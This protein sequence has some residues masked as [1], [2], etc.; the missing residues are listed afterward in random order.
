MYLED[1]EILCTTVNLGVCIV[2][3]FRYLRQWGGVRGGAVGWGTVL[4]TGRS[5]VRFPMES[6]EFFSDL[7]LPGG[8]D[9]RCVGLATLPP[10]CADCLDI[11]GASISWNPLGPVT[12]CSGKALP[13]PLRQWG[14]WKLDIKGINERENISTW[15]S[16]AQYCFM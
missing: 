3:T 2:S 14:I 16:R 15:F 1:S 4:Q 10:S 7:I 12:A 9:G 6:L 13:L 11:L 5:R 8:K